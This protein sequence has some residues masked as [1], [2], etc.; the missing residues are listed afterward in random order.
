MAD[1]MAVA[2]HDAGVAKRKKRFWHSWAVWF[3]GCGLVQMACQYVFGWHF[4]DGWY[5]SSFMAMFVCYGLE[6]RWG[7]KLDRLTRYLAGL[8]PRGTSD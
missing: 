2:V 8:V 3:G 6:W 4:V 5:Q 7:K 1:L